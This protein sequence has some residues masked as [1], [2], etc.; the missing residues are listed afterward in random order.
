MAQ[1]QMVSRF[2]KWLAARR[3]ELGFSQR[4]LAA[5][6]DI[7]PGYIARLERG[8]SRSPSLELIR[9]LSKLLDVPVENIPRSSTPSVSFTQISTSYPRSA[10]LFR[11]IIHKMS[12][13]ELA[14]TIGRL[15]Q[16]LALFDEDPESVAENFIEVLTGR[17]KPDDG[18]GLL[19]RPVGQY[20]RPWS[21]EIDEWVSAE[22][23]FNAL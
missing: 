8:Y 4:E 15:E 16:R 5:L 6:A 12:E 23:V 13:R 21:E 10:L 14:S 11:N 7:S 9:K 17:R 1:F 3:K 22:D 18:E 2:G 19:T 20:F